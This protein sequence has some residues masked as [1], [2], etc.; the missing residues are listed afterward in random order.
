MKSLLKKMSL[1]LAMLGVL[2]VGVSVYAAD[3]DMGPAETS[4]TCPYGPNI[5]VGR[6]Y[7]ENGQI[8]G[9]WKCDCNGSGLVWGRYTSTY[10]QF[11]LGFCN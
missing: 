2:S 9:Y 11:A 5:S 7:M 10:N 1:C 6:N 8:V 4:L 3:S